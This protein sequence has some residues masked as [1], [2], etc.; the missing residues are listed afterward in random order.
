M[1]GK[2]L[3]ITWPISCKWLLVKI[4]FSDLFCSWELATQTWWRQGHIYKWNHQC[5]YSLAAQSGRV[6]DHELLYHL[7]YSTATGRGE[8]FQLSTHCFFKSS[9][10]LI[11]KPFA[12]LIYI[13][14]SLYSWWTLST[15]S[16]IMQIL[17]LAETEFL[18]LCIDSCFVWVYFLLWWV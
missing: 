12:L 1:R 11:W 15:F 2:I 5:P 8:T 18:V 16:F 4:R 14:L 6:C 17:F 3:P 13:Y 7:L 9:F 10:S